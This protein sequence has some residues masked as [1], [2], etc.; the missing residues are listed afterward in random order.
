VGPAADAAP[1]QRVKKHHDPAKKKYL[2]KGVGAQQ[3]AVSAA[4]LALKQA[5]PQGQQITSKEAARRIK[6]AQRG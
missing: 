6:A 2:A 3:N 5:A 1:I 4:A